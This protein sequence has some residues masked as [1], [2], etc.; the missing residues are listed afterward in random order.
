MIVL[1]AALFVLSALITLLILRAGGNGPL[2]TDVAVAG[3]GP[4]AP[5]EQI[6]VEKVIEE[7]SDANAL[8]ANEWSRSGMEMGS[9]GPLTVQDFFLPESVQ[10][11]DAGP[12]LLRR[13]LDRWS[14]EQIRRYWIPLEDIALDL[15]QRENDRRIEA[16]FEDIP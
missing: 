14:E 15:I 8:G 3:T 7:F 13:R 12:Y 1:F 4:A 6:A 2:A 10:P 5:G 16:L 9:R 11:D